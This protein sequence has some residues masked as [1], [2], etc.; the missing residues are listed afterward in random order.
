VAG[1]AFTVQR[2]GDLFILSGSAVERLSRLSLE[3]RDAREY[4]YERLE[5]LGA[6]AELRRQGLSD[7]H[8]LRLGKY[9]LIYRGNS[10]DLAS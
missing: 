2:Q 1:P 4:L 8:R 3:E 5:A 6:L 7:G 10:F 9:Q